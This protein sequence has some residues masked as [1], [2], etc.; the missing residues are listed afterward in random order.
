MSKD[1]GKGN[2]DFDVG[3][4][5][6]SDGEIGSN[7]SNDSNSGTELE[8]DVDK[9]Y[10]EYDEPGTEEDDEAYDDIE[11][12]ADFID[13]V[14]N[15]LYNS[16]NINGSELD[17]VSI[18]GDLETELEK[19]EHTK[20]YINDDRRI[21]TK[22][23]TSYERARIIGDRTKMIELGAKPMVVP[24]DPDSGIYMSSKEIA[25]AELEQGVLPFIIERALPDGIIEQWKVNELLLKNYD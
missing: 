2:V 10:E 6:E 13:G 22:Y 20:I 24:K 12:D 23:L 5:Y 21:T 14:P 16:N 11:V 17:E 25:L 7:Q 1:K 4:E 8:L 9:E 3:S 19:E 15:C 18:D